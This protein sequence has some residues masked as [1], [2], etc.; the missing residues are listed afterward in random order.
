M[1]YT[2]KIGLAAFIIALASIPVAHAQS[3]R[4][5]FE[6]ASVKPSNSGRPG[7]S[8]ETEPGRFKAINATVSF[9][10]QYA[11]S[12]K[13][14]QLSGG[15]GWIGSDKFDI[16]ARSEAKAQD[17][18]DREFP[19]M[20]RTLLAD[21]FHLKFHREMKE[22]P[23][24]ALTVAKGGPKLTPAPKEENRSTRRSAGGQLTVM[25]GTV[26]NL[27]S[28]LSNILGRTV[29]ENTGLIGSYDMTLK[30]T[31]DEYQ[32]PPLRPD[33]PPA[34]PNGPSIFTALQE[35]LGLKLESAKGP[36]EVLVIDSVSKPS[37]N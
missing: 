22:L 20:M 8:I 2:K 30:W 4:P 25:N 24:Y 34:D 27:A 31:P 19:P 18:G 33:L 37:E 14:F 13:D 3:S 12:L 28:A 15:P 11:F 16:D 32:A 29:V 1:S 6:V 23:V 10:I 36:V 5:A 35:Q 21:R 26:A 7:M 17:L 9:L